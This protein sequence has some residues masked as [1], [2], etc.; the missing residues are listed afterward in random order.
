MKTTL[1]ML[2]CVDVCVY[3]RRTIPTRWSR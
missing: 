2:C 3:R 1:V